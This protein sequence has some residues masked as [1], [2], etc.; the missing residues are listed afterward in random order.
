MQP[1]LVV[2]V[3]LTSK[4][5]RV[6]NNILLGFFNVDEAGLPFWKFH[7]QLDIALLAVSVVFI[8]F[9]RAGVQPFVLFAEKLIFTVSI[10]YTILSMVVFALQPKLSFTNI[11]TSLY[12]DGKV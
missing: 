3:S 1:L 10:T 8:K 2:T 6:L 4:E 5:S 7:N 11:T 9:T 12:P